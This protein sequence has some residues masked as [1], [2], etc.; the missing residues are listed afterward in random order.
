MGRN[1]AGLIFLTQAIT[2]LE[3]RVGD[4]KKC[5]IKAATPATEAATALTISKVTVH[6]NL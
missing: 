4:W 5:D 3:D 6:W 1:S 2:E